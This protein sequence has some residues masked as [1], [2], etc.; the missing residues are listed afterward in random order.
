M[1]AGEQLGFLVGSQQRR[2][3]GYGLRAMI[4]ERVHGR[5][6]YSAAI[7][8]GAFC[9]AFHTALGVAGMAMSSWPNASVM[10][11]IT[12]AGAAMAPASPQPFTPRGFEGQGV[13][14]MATWKVGKSPARGMQ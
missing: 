8:A 12:A 10:A 7:L 6:S 14:V 1:A 11:L 5:A 13:L 9:A 3:I 4:L 2:R